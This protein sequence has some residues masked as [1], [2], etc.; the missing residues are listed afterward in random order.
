VLKRLLFGAADAPPSPDEIS[1]NV[2][3]AL[4]L[5]FAAYGP[6]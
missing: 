6:A 2:D 1:R 4:Q 5:F 3:Q